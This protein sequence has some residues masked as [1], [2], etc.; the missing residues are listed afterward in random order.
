MEIP[1]LIRWTEAMQVLNSVDNLTTNQLMNMANFEVLKCI[2]EQKELPANDFDLK[3]FMEVMKAFCSDHSTLRK[4][5]S[6]ED[7]RIFTEDQ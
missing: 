4:V 6:G 2:I 3:F 1:Q 7:I 5:L